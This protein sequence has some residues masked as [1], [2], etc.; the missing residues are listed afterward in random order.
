[1]GRHRGWPGQQSNGSGSSCRPGNPRLGREQRR[2]LFEQARH[3]AGAEADRL[4]LAV[5]DA[6]RRALDTAGEAWR[7]PAAGVDKRR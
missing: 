7:R 1:V 5:I 2:Q 4:W 6:Y 3:A